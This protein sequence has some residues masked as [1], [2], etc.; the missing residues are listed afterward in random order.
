MTDFMVDGK[1][2]DRPE[3][4]KVF[5]VFGEFEEPTK[6]TNF[7][8]VRM[9]SGHVPWSKKIV[10]AINRLVRSF[11]NDKAAYWIVD[12]EPVVIEPGNFYRDSK[13]PIPVSKRLWD[14]TA[15]L[16]YEWNGT[17]LVQV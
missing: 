16:H 17:E 4:W 13:Q 12:G 15:A 14:N 10:P 6:K 3:P 9:P 11:D 2:V 7:V 8:I 5:I 1:I